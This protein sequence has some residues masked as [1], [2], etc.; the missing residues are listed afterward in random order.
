MA[1]LLEEHVG[2]TTIVRHSPQMPDE[3][4]DEAAD[5]V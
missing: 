5:A 4:S 3:K 2:T 1:A